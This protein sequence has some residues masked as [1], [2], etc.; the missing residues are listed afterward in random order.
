VNEWEES[1]LVLRFKT[2]AIKFDN[3][4][5][6]FYSR[7]S[8]FLSSCDF[9][10]WTDRAIYFLEVKDAN[11]F[12]APK[13]DSIQESIEKRIS[14]KLIE[15]C[16]KKVEQISKEKN[17]TSIKNLLNSI[18][19]SLDVLCKDI[20]S[21]LQQFGKEFI[22]ENVKEL[23]KNLVDTVGSLTLANEEKFDLGDGSSL[24]KIQRLLL[25]K[26]KL[27]LNI[28][29]NDSSLNKED[30]AIL[31]EIAERLESTVDIFNVEVIVES[32]K[33]YDDSL[34]EISP[35]AED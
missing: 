27:F 32:T 28:V 26:K 6:E 35:L 5:K 3:K 14:K 31:Q 9:V 29:I 8:S 21:I 20:N 33:E 18:Q 7:L 19:Q 4:S 1:N 13:E 17:C 23:C 10:Y 22:D 15:K 34:K 11:F 24:S 12:F 25:E 16:I 30:L 2:E